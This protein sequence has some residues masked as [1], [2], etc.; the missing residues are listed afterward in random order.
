M[1]LLDAFDMYKIDLFDRQSTTDSWGNA[2]TGYGSTATRTFDGFIQPLSGNQAVANNKLTES[3]THIL[4]TKDANIAIS[5]RVRKT[6][7]T[8]L[9]EVRFSNQ[10]DGIGGEDDH[11]EILLEVIDV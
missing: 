4:Y 11:R 9:Y 10:Q 3:S 8:Q 5:S 7:T 2:S 6:G 1:G